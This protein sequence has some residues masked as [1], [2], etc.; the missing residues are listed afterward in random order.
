LNKKKC[1]WDK[2]ER[3]EEREKQG[4]RIYGVISYIISANDVTGWIRSVTEKFR[5]GPR[6]VQDRAGWNF[7]GLY[8]LKCLVCVSPT[9]RRNG[10]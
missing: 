8:S 2:E 9:R 10:T 3:K 7:Q 1:R 6:F 5:V 4:G